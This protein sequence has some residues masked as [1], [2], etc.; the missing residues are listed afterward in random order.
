MPFWNSSLYGLFKYYDRR[1]AYDLGSS[2]EKELLMILIIWLNPY[3]KYANAQLKTSNK[4][5]KCYNVFLSDL[6][7]ADYKYLIEND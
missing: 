7:H 4:K 1:N 2:V 3:L 5:Y 6:F